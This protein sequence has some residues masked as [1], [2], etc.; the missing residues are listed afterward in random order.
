MLEIN[1]KSYEYH[2]L[3][4]TENLGFSFSTVLPYINYPENIVCDYDHNHLTFHF[5]A[6][7]W[8]SPNKIRY[9]YKVEGFKNEWSYPTIDNK[10]DYRNLPFGTFTFKV[11]AIGEAQI[12]SDP[13]EYTFTILPPW[14]HTW[15]AR[16]AYG[17]F[18]LLLIISY[19]RWRTISL[20]KRQKELESEVEIA[21]KDLVVKNQEISEQKEEIWYYIDP[22]K[23]IKEINNNEHI[24]K[25][26]DI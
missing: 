14:Y 13:F 15:W 8:S 5:N 22:V 12:W 23:R 19:V 4:Q 16:I 7:D 1:E 6:I 2:N 25:C 26:I 24:K 20:K 18:S 9:S 10:V 21:T 3:S 11:R 17:A